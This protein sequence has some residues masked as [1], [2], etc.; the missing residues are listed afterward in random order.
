MTISCTEKQKYRQ[1]RWKSR[2]DCQ[3]VHHYAKK[4][5]ED[6]PYEIHIQRLH[7]L[8]SKKHSEDSRW[9]KEQ[10]SKM[11]NNLSNEKIKALPY[12]EAFIMK[13]S[14]HCHNHALNHGR[15]KSINDIPEA[16]QGEIKAF[17]DVGQRRISLL[18]AQL[19]ATALMRGEDP[20]EVVP[21]G[22]VLNRY[23][24][25]YLD[26]QVTKVVLMEEDESMVEEEKQT[27]LDAPLL[28][29]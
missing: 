11:L 24:N 3:K 22:P 27:V 4:I 7:L 29:Y 10:H 23:R 18:K 14:Q 13:K 21:P 19:T 9:G 28:L 6:C 1:D 17:L 12:E 16:V 8:H 20:S 5:I 25:K 26:D 2:N 15:L